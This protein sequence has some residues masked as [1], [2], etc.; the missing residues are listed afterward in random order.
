MQLRLGIISITGLVLACLACGPTTSMQL[1]QP[2]W[3]TGAAAFRGHEDLSRFAV[4]GANANLAGSFVYPAIPY[5]ENGAISRHP[6]VQGNYESDFPSARM[7]GF[8]GVNRNVDWHND[9]TLQFIHGLR[10]HVSGTLVSNRQACAT[11]QQ[12]ILRTADAALRDYRSGNWESGM[13][14]AGHALHI[15]QDTYSPAH[16]SRIGFEG[17]QIIDF[18]SYSIRQ[19][20]TCFHDKVDQRDRVWRT[21]SLSCT[22]DSDKRTWDCLS[23]EARNAAIASAAL[24]EQLARAYTTNGNIVVHMNQLFNERLNCS[25]L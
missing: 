19:N 14:W 23:P 9:A 24:L 21:D 22:F 18:C 12:A 8:Y 13:Y 6:I 17:R 11:V 16:V 20:G 3:H 4:D 25:G 5:G 15:I 10:N 7:Y 1:S 2:N